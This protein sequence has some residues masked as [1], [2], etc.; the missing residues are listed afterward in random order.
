MARIAAKQ[1]PPCSRTR[2]GK[3][4]AVGREFQIGAIG[5]DQHCKVGDAD[6]PGAFRN[7]RVA[8][9]QTVANQLLEI[10]GRFGIEFQANDAAAA[11]TLDRAAEVTN[12][13]FGLLLDLDI[14][15]AKHAERPVAEQI[16]T[17]ET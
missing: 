6:E 8:S 11:T 4:R 3:T 13:V 5:F 12:E 10:F 7:Q 2:S 1:S 17:R 15:V 9:V 16:E 14:A